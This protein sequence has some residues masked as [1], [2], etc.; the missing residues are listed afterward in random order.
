MRSSEW[1]SKLVSPFY[2][3][4]LVTCLFV[5]ILGCGNK[6]ARTIEQYGDVTTSPGGISLIDPN[7]HI[8]GWGRR[9]C[10]LCHN[11]SLNIHRGPSSSLDPDQINEQAWRNGGSKYC[12]SCHG[13]NGLY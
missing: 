13:P 10:L 12:L 8:G 4:L 11:S 3:S 7:E 5:I 1:A 2:I 6:D 9:D